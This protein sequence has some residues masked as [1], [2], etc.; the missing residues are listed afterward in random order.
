[1]DD[2]LQDRRVSK[3]KVADWT[4]EE[5]SL[6]SR[7]MVKFPGGSPGRWDKIAQELGRSV[8]D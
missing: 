4:D 1:M 3:K 7:L 2:W 8:T 5:L 6:L